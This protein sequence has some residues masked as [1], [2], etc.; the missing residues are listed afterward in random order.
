MVEV[1]ATILLHVLFGDISIRA[2]FINI[3]NLAVHALLGTFFNDKRVR[4]ILPTDRKI[5]AFN[6][7]LVLILVVLEVTSVGTTEQLTKIAASIYTLQEQEPKLVRVACTV[8][9]QLFA[10]TSVLN[11]SKARGFV[12]VDAL[13]VFK[14]SY[15]CKVAC[16]VLNIIFFRPLYALILNRTNTAIKVA[17]HQCVAPASPSAV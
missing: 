1:V 6:S 8:T 3:R 12:Q 14:Q 4:S 17:I 15:P 7:S 11:T 2:I 10:E 9:F 5:I 13:T 16:S